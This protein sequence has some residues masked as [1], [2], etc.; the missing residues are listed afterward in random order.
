MDLQRGSGEVLGFSGESGEM[1]E[2]GG[3]GMKGIKFNDDNERLK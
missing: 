3:I 2:K 1:G